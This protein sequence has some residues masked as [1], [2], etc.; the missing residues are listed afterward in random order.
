MNPYLIHIAFIILLMLEAVRNNMLIDQGIED[1]ESFHNNNMRIRLVVIAIA[2]FILDFQGFDWYRVLLY[3]GVTGM[4][5]FDSFM[6]FTLKGDVRYLGNQSKLD[7]LQR[8]RASWLQ[9]PRVRFTIVWILKGLISGI[10]VLILH[11]I[12]LNF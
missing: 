1:Q 8:G 4:W 7:R 10:S 5:L 9:R 12:I 2:T 3:F 11:R 6:G